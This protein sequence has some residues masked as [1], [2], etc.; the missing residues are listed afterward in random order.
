MRETNRKGKLEMKKATACLVLGTFLMSPLSAQAQ[1]NDAKY[2]AAMIDLYRT[3]VG[4]NRASGPVPEAIAACNSGNTAAGIP[5]L[6]QALKDAQ[7]TLP[8][9]N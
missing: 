6:E 2:C 5:V 9:R 3:Y 4:A 8:P 1:S 7:I